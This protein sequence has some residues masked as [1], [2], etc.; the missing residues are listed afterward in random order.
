MDVSKNDKAM[1]V[2]DPQSEFLTN[3]QTSIGVIDFLFR[4]YAHSMRTV[5]SH[6]D[7]HVMC[8]GHA[9]RERAADQDSADINSRIVG[10]SEADRSHKD[11]R[12]AAWKV[13]DEVLDELW[14]IRKLSRISVVG[15]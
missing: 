14:A 7:S 6:W 3:C 9:K 11:P 4:R 10:M 15:S 12:K 2:T 13:K 5:R 8:G 1:L